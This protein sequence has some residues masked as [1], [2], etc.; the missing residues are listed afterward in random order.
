MLILQPQTSQKMSKNAISSVPGKEVLFGGQN[1]KSAKQGQSVQ[2]SR[3]AQN[4]VY[5]VFR[6]QKSPGIDCDT[7]KNDQGTRKWFFEHFLTA[8][9]GIMMQKTAIFAYF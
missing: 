2:K 9:R 8:V 6:A 1:F 4:R 5:T 3:K 7:Q